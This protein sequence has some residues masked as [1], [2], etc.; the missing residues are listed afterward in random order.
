MSSG[1]DSDDEVI[2][3]AVQRVLAGAARRREEAN[4]RKFRINIFFSNKKLK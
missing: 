3:R 1:S 2:N 4:Q